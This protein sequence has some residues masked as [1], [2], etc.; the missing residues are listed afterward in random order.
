[1]KKAKINW[2]DIMVYKLF[3]WRFNKK[4]IDDKG[5]LKMFLR[6]MGTWAENNPEPERSR[7]DGP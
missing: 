1:M 7:E 4:F 3:Y 5:L 2:F 6:W